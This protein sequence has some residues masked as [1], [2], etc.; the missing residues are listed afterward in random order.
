M[1][2]E[3]L[4]M[5]V[6]ASTLGI[7]FR[8]AVPLLYGSLGGCF[9]QTSGC[10]NIAYEC[11]MLFGALFGVIGSFYTGNPWIGALCAMGIGIL[12]ALIFGMFT[13]VFHSNS[14]VVGVALNSGAWAMT[15]L[16]MVSLFGSRG[17]FTD[18]G[19]INFS[20]LNTSLIDKIPY[21][22]SVLGQ[23]VLPVYL[24][25]A[26][27]AVSY[28]VMFKTPFGL[29]I[30]GVGQNE[31]AAETAGISAV[32]YRMISLVMMGAFVGLS[33]CC[34]SLGGLSMFSE[35][36]TA[37]RGFLCVASMIVGGGNPIKIALVALLFAYSDAMSQ[38]LTTLG[39][40]GL[41][42]STIPY[43]A[44]IVVL[45]IS[46]IKSFKGTADLEG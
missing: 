6:Y 1:G 28:I 43:I 19:I 7:T 27:I 38:I 40:N 33:G 29:R 34:L 24:A 9:N 18:P 39:L 4:K 22:G 16:L 21:L 31:V 10:N 45:L 12:V 36:M 15:T 46:G 37:G 14:I 42:V 41:L 44:V 13:I 26:M 5:T 20:R 30:R 2:W 8:S 35:N 3:I 23:N 11:V 25:Y 17:S 32:K